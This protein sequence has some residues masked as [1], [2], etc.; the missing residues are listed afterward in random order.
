MLNPKPRRV[1]NFLPKKPSIYVISVLLFMLILPIV[2]II[3]EQGES[4]SLHRW[5][6]IGK[7]FVFWGVGVRL[8]VAGIRQVAKPEFTAREIFHMSGVEGL[9]IIKELGFANISIGLAGIV[10]LFK[11]EWTELA[12]IAGGLFFGLAGVLHVIK[13]P[14]SFNEWV[15]MISDLFFFGVI[16]LYLCFRFA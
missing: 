12:G 2:S 13:R 6:L 5:P 4:T 14:D 9:V 11:P 3:V 7:W 10:S 1:W 15:A 16:G 8:F